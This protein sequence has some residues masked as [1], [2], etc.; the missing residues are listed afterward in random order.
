MCSNKLF[1]NVWFY[2]LKFSPAISRRD[3]FVIAEIISNSHNRLIFIL[4][5]RAAHKT[6]TCPSLVHCALEKPYRFK[7]IELRDQPSFLVLGIGKEQKC[8][9]S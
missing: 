7:K 8:R 1:V 6:T 3:D 5:I 9:L 2:F 4:L